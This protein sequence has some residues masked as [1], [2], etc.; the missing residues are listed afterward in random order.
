LTTQLTFTGRP[1]AAAASMPS[2]TR[3]TGKSASFIARKVSSSSA[4][5]ETVTRRSPAS[6]SAAAFCGRS[7]A[8]V[9]S[10]RSRPS[11]ASIAISRSS[12]RRTSGSPPV[13]RIFCTPSA[14]K[15]RAVRAIS[16]NES[17]S[18]RSRKR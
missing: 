12:S 15:T 2:S 11:S 16:S 18:R 5:S 8:F 17:S 9:V 1:A 13:M 4:S 3:A 10:V 14:A 7:D 6:A